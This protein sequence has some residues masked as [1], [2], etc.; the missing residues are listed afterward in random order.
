MEENKGNTILIVIILI[1]SIALCGT[2]T[3]IVMS[4][5]DESFVNE[6]SCAYTK[7]K[8]ASLLAESEKEEIISSLKPL[9]G[10]NIVESEF[11]SE[12]DYLYKVEC[13]TDFRGA[14]AFFALVW[15]ENGTWK[16]VSYIYTG[17]SQDEE[18]VT[19][20]VEEINNLCK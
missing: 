19:Q 2:I 3:F 5:A 7:L 1:L 14:N 20:K 15:K 17:E 9:D 12:S 18:V 8:Q 16:Y 4:R 13:T 6:K 11:T 10:S